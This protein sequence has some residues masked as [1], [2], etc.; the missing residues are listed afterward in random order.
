[1]ARVV[2]TDR[3]AENPDEQDIPEAG[4]FRLIVDGRIYERSGTDADGVPIY[5]ELAY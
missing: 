1:M 4:A 5:R 3:N 2:L